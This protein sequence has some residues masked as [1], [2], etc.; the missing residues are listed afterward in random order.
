MITLTFPDGAQRQY[1]A[2][3]TGRAV[4]ASI[5]K[6]LEKKAVAMALDGRLRDLSDPIENDAAIRLI[7]REDP[8]S[9]RNSSGMIARMFWPRRCRSSF[10][11]RRSHR[12]GDRERLLLRLLSRPAVHAGRFSRH[13]EKDARDHRARQAVHEARDGRATRPKNSSATM[14]RCSRWSWSMRIPEGEPIKF[15]TQGDWIDLCR[16]PHMTSTGKIGNAFKL[17]KVAGAYWRGDARNPML[18]AHLRHGLRERR[19]NSKHIF[20]RS[21]K[22]RSAITAARAGNGFVPLPGGRARR[23]VLASEGLGV[24]PGNRELLCAGGGRAMTMRKSIRRKILGQVP[25]GNVRPL[26][27]VSREHVLHRDRGRTGLRA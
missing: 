13:R 27:L 26:G 3:T 14:A 21:R 20:A 4:A 9:A 12:A 15:Y 18:T 22:R 6:S 24:V 8:E 1:E 5:A 10:P 16:G 19:R 17:M 11:A 25:V 7:M 23:R 2:G